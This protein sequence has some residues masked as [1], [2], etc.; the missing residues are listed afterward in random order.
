MANG[1]SIL[2]CRTGV[3][4][5]RK[6]LSLALGVIGTAS[7]SSTLSAQGQRV[8]PRAPSQPGPPPR[9]LLAHPNPVLF[10]SDTA[11]QLDAL[12]HSVDAKDA[13]APGPC[14]ASRALALAHIVM[15]DAC[16][17][18]YDSGFESFYLRGGRAPANEFA[19]VFVGGAVARILGHI[20][21]TPAHAHLIGFQRQHFLKYFDSRALEA[22]NEGLEFGRNERFTSQWQWDTIKNAATSSTSRG[23][24]LR[25]G[26]H[27]V[28]PFILIKSSMASPGA[29][30]LR[31]SPVYRS[32]LT[33]PAIRPRKMIVSMYEI[34]MRCGS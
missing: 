30:F 9:I 26:E 21:T 10:W 14:A 11:L 8:I 16:V 18:A 24:A 22:W 25:R 32:I 17:A 23:V 33:A 7:G 13:R 29:E 19:D 2:T 1:R 34:L 6:A 4:D 12:D 3:L 28:D 20:Y 5:R 31:C 15:A 27:D